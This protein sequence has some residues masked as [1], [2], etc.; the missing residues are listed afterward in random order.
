MINWSNWF[1]LV[2]GLLAGVGILR[3]WQEIRRQARMYRA[4][5]GL[6]ASQREVHLREVDEL[7]REAAELRELAR[8]AEIRRKPLETAD[9]SLLPTQRGW[10][11]V[12]TGELA[13]MFLDQWLLA[14]Y[15]DVMVLPD[16]KAMDAGAWRAFVATNPWAKHQP[17][18]FWLA[19]T[20]EISQRQLDA[21]IEE[22]VDRLAKLADKTGFPP[23]LMPGFR[24]GVGSKQ[25]PRGSRHV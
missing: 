12:P 16:L 19:T 24:A 11:D 1:I 4:R 25:V 14:N 23:E 22:Y 6:P 17:K 18:L 20:I 15:Y 5:P 7:I 3:A 21:A 9:G 2:L 13:Y 10:G 8:A